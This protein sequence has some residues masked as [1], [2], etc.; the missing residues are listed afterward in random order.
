[1]NVP[2]IGHI[3]NTS[4]ITTPWRDPGPDLLWD[5]K[6]GIRINACIIGAIPLGTYRRLDGRW[7]QRVKRRTGGYTWRRLGRKDPIPNRIKVEA[8]LLEVSI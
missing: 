8:L 2:I 3:H 4:F 5:P 6:R 1:M 7:F